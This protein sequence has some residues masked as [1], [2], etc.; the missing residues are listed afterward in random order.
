MK[1]PA[2][3]FCPPS[4]HDPGSDRGSRPVNAVVVGAARRRPWLAATAITN[5]LAAFGG[6]VG[7]TTGTLALDGDLNERLPFASP[8]LGGIALA[9]LV[10]TPFMAVAVL[11]WRG[12]RRCELAAGVTGVLLVGW[13]AVQLAVLRA[14]AF[15]HAFYLA[16]GVAFAWYGR[17]AFTRALR[18]ASRPS[19]GHGVR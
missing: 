6:A 9:A 17:A 10:A 18:S 4:V 19:L 15:L 11:A 1:V 8:V 14:P 2:T 12:D 3:D 16:V 5:A 13:I 7:L